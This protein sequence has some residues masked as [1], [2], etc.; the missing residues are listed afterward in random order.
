MLFSFYRMK[1]RCRAVKLPN[2]AQLGNG[3]TIILTQA[4]Q[5]QSSPCPQ[6]AAD[7]AR[8]PA[9]M[10]CESAHRNMAGPKEQE[11]SV[12]T[13]AW[14]FWEGFPQGVT[15]EWEERRWTQGDVTS[16]ARV[17]SG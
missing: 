7:L 6:G 14:G 4:A 11:G 10:Q 17:R 5:L 9:N 3:Q 13:W 8:E 15:S 12:G 1:L 16:P 2:V